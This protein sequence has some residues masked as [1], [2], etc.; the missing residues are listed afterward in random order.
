MVS[1]NDNAMTDTPT[2]AERADPHFLYELSVQCAEAEVDFVDATYRRLRGRNA[3]LLREDFCGTANVS[4]E[5]VKRRRGNRAIGIDIDPQVLAWGR[6]NNLQRL[7]PAQRQRLQLI[8]EDVLK[9]RTEPPDIVS[10]MNFSY[11]LF[12]ERKQLKRYF[13]SV[14]NTLAD[15]GILFLDAYGGYDSFRIIEEE[16]E[17]DAEGWQFKYIWE[18]ERY[19]PISGGMICNIHFT[20]P[21]GSRLERAFRYDWR[22]WTLAEIRDLLEE[23]GFRNIRVYWQGWDADGEPDGNFQLAQEGEAEAGWICYLTAEK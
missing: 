13:R 5:W 17:I 3:R 9:A 6:A 7:S 18:Q 1:G 23:A 10:A 16:R 15:D 21:D 12:K 4:C 11:W 2:L 8:P 14:K 19:D 22:L 20:F